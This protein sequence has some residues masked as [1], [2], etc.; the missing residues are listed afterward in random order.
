LIR[1]LPELLEA[2][3]GMMVTVAPDPLTAV[4]RGTGIILDNLEQ[5]KEALLTSDDELVPT[6]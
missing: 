6:Q 3:L 1:G 4:V 2:A 5:Y